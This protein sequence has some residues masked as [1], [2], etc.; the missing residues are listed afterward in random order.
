MLSLNKL[1]V[2]FLELTDQQN[3]YQTVAL[4][5]ENQELI[6][7]KSD[8][9]SVL[10]YILQYSTISKDQVCNIFKEA[11]WENKEFNV[12]KF[13]EFMILNHVI[14]DQP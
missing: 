5:S 13:I 6:A 1:A 3:G 14:I 11:D 4:N 9:Y 8:G 10:R 2:I 12:S 7:I